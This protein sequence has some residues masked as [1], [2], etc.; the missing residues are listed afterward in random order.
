MYDRRSKDA[1][2]IHVLSRQSMDLDRPHPFITAG[3]RERNACRWMPLPRTCGGH[4]RLADSTIFTTLVGGTVSL[5]PFWH[6][7]AMV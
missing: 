6:H 2:S 1:Q 5:Q 4:I 7:V 3:N